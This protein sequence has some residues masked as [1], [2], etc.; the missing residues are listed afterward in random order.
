MRITT[1]GYIDLRDTRRV[2]TPGAFEDRVE[3]TPETEALSFLLS[4]SFPGHRKVVRPMTVSDRKKIQMALWA[5]TVSERMALVDRVWRSMT[6]P[7]QPPADP[8]SPQL[9][10]VV[11]YGDAWS[12]PI[13]LDG[14]VTRVI[15]H[16]GVPMAELE[17]ADVLDLQ[18][19]K[20]SA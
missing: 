1:D 14:T 3:P 4:H 7:V 12:Y 11:T 2:R 19:L 9:V 18:Q 10:Q 17:R 6:E 5:D 8:S 15:P 16:G 13:Y 20:K